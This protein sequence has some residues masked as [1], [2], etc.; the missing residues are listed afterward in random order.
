MTPSPDRQL[1]TRQPGA[2]GFSLRRLMMPGAIVAAVVA[3]G[4]ATVWRTSAAVPSMGPARDAAPAVAIAGAPSGIPPTDAEQRDLNIALYDSA[5]RSDPSSAY[6]HT[7]LAAHYLQ[8]A[9]ETGAATDVVRAE[10]AARAALALRTQHNGAAFVTL[11]SALLSQ[12]RFDEAG[13]IA[14]QLVAG[15]PDVPQYRAQ[16]GEV[17]LELGNYA[18]ARAAFDSVAYDRGSLGIAPRLAR[19]ADIRGDTAAAR[20]IFARAAA[21][22]RIDD[23]MPREQVAW[24][25]MRVGDH[26]L[27]YGALAAA[28]S[29]Y[30]R[31]LDLRPDDYR[32]LAAMA[33]LSAARGDWPG[34]IDYGVRATATVPE[35][36][37]LALVGQAY[38]ATG[39]S[40]KA[41][42]YYE[43]MEAATR[44]ERGGY[45]RAWALS[46]LDRGL[47]V[48]DVQRK[49]RAELAIR[50]DI[51]DLD[52]LAWA[53]YKRGR[54]AEARVAMREALAQGTQD[55]LLF[56][57]AG[58][59]ER[60]A[61]DPVQARTLLTRALAINPYFDARQPAVARATLD[62]IARAAPA[63]QQSP[64]VVRAP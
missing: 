51:H 48:D 35:P 54:Y 12:H 36:A 62:S 50:R 31:G 46:R 57:H 61:G 37:P 5:T 38:A 53:E 43:R 21:T 56:H 7:Q 44:G 14:R 47:R 39:D 29:A 33:R 23:A 17:E 11:V 60:A 9:R 45:H 8:R 6:F 24:F 22:A 63:L 4:L 26:A 64:V 15:E 1:G 40:A 13:R 3:A 19:W 32:L 34:V 52:L 16:L 18:A 10:A 58:M 25:E 41:A 42:Q 55:A 59:I 49:V 20:A 27:R 2:G 28:D 30:R